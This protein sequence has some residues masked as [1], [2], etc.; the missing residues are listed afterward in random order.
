MITDI[1]SLSTP[2]LS[3]DF[4]FIPEKGGEFDPVKESYSDRDIFL[5]VLEEAR[6]VFSGMLYGYTFAY[7][8][9]DAARN[10]DES[11]SIELLHNIKMGDPSLK[12]VETW[13]SEYKHYITLEY[14]LAPFQSEFLN[15]WNSNTIPI[16]TG[17][18]EGSF[19]TG[20]EGKLESIKTSIKNG[21]RNYLR[22]RRYNKPKEIKG[23]VLL[24]NPPI[25]Q[26][27]SGK[28]AAEVTFKL[29][30][31]EIEDYTAY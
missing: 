21:I 11:F 1:F 2:Y 6:Y 12:A 24:W 30:V 9:S 18:G 3:A 29:L 31:D 20:L 17:S 26:T 4:W 27:R 5:K 8:P 25:I 10:V 19:Y 16:V 23:A 28:Y 13:E 7:I 15:S 22:T 14:N